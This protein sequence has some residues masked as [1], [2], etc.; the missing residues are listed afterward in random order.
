MPRYPLPKGKFLAL[1]AGR[2][3]FHL[4]TGAHIYLYTV[5]TQ[6]GLAIGYSSLGTSTDLLRS[7]V[8][9]A[10]FWILVF[11]GRGISHTL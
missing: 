6:R 2:A 5:F 1:D 9:T 3:F 11:I 10:K 8:A 7:L 4:I